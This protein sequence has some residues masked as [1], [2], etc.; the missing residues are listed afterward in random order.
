MTIKEFQEKAIEENGLFVLEEE[1]GTEDGGGSR[2]RYFQDRKGKVQ[3]SEVDFSARRR[4]TGRPCSSHF[5]S[6]E[7]NIAVDGSG[8]VIARSLTHSSQREWK[9]VRGL[10][11]DLP[12]NPMCSPPTPATASASCASIWTLQGY[13]PTSPSTPPS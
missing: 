10:L 7:D 5:F 9:A 1:G 12:S 4:H 6:Y 13:L 8:F 2:R 11:R 3:L